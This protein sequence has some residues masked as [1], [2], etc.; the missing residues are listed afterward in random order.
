M[1]K[2]ALIIEDHP[3]FRDALMVS[4]RGIF[5]ESRLLA[6]SSAE[7][8]LSHVKAGGSVDI[9]MLDLGLPG[10]NGVEA[11]A[12]F[13]RKCPAAAIIVI[14]ASEERREVDAVLRAGA[15]AFISKAASAQVITDIM[16]KVLNDEPLESTW[17]SRGGNQKFC[18]EQAL[19][20]T[21]RQRES[22]VLLCQGL[23]NKEIGL[24]LGV[25]E[26]TVKVH[27]SSIFRTFSVRNRTQAVLAARRLGI[28]SPEQAE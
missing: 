2:F 16:R 6:V 12:S 27:I 22:L 9:V 7:E 21:P 11:V 13:R 23:S 5:D 17:I 8:G 14:S 25:S 18:E 15:T 10:M 4:M 1:T 3:I 20:L 24:R 19:M 28:F 26:I